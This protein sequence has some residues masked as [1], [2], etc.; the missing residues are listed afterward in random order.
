MATTT[1]QK[2][3]EKRWKL[4][5]C[6][7]GYYSTQGGKCR[8]HPFPARAMG[9]PMQEIEVIPGD[10]PNVLQPEEARLLFTDRLRLSG[11]EALDR[12]ALLDR[13]RPTQQDKETS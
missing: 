1:E 2:Q 4:F 12:D 6:E 9:P 13:L 7:C 10:A 3:V 11:S 8:S 5:V